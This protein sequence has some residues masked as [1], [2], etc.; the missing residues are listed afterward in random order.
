ME[1]KTEIWSGEAW[2]RREGGATDCMRREEGGAERERDRAR[3]KRERGIQSC[4]N[5]NLER[6]LRNQEREQA[7]TTTKKKWRQIYFTHGEKEG[8]E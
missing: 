7:T 4:L 5:G 1:S 6:R 8:N 3:E 2:R